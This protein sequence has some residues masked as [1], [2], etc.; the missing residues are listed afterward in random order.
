M[1]LLPGGSPAPPRK[2]RPGHLRRNQRRRRRRARRQLRP[3]KHPLQA[4]HLLL[5]L[6]HPR[7]RWLPARRGE[8]RRRP[9]NGPGKQ[10]S[11]PPLRAARPPGAFRRKSPPANRGHGRRSSSRTGGQG[12][13]RRPTTR[14]PLTSSHPTLSSVSRHPGFRRADTR[15]PPS[16]PRHLCPTRRRSTPA[17]TPA[18]LT[19]GPGRGG[20]CAPGTSS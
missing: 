3:P 17:D 19:P 9:G 2:V 14:C 11:S 7:R 18:R 4:S 5:E 20:R 16:T 1:P 13:G 10:P 15:T 8:K 12:P 6:R